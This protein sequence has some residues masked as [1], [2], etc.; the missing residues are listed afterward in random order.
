VTTGLSDGERIEVASGL[1]DGERVITTGA[2]AL[3][4]GDR[5][6]LVTDQKGRGGRGNRTGGTPGSGS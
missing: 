1:S 3:R 4:D 6:T 2:T 5:I